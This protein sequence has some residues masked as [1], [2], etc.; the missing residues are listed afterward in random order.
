MYDKLPLPVKITSVRNDSASVRTI[1]FDH[2][3]DGR[4]GQF[5]MVWIPG[6]DEIPMALSEPNAITVQMIGDGTRILGGMQ[7]GEKIGIRGPFGNGFTPVGRVMAIAGGVGTAPLL[8]LAR[9]VPDV[10]FLQGSRSKDDLLFPDILSSVCT[11]HVAT[12]DGTLGYHGYVAGLLGTFDLS[13]FDSICVCGPDPMMKAVLDI[14]VEK[15]A[16]SRSQ[17]SLHRYMKCGVGLCGS[18]CMDPEGL[19]VC[20]DGPVFS[21]DRLLNQEV[22]GH[23]RD[24]TGQK[25]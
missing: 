18:C 15:D 20:R 1:F 22:W 19:C 23:H 7:P 4:P 24:G 3:F 12:D 8:P 5:V 13:E 16:V 17:F 14:L 11:L 25:Q 21:G 10:V 9:S 2:R 6:I